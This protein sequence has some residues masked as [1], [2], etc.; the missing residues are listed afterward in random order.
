MNVNNVN[1]NFINYDCTS[2]VKKHKTIPL[3]GTYQ[4]SGVYPVYMRPPY[5]IK[6][7]FKVEEFILPTG[8]K[9]CT[10]KLITGQIISIVQKDG[11]PLIKTAF[12]VGSLDEPYGKEGISHF[13]EHSVFHG[14]K[15]YN[16]VE[17]A[18]KDI[19]GTSNASTNCN[20][21]DFYI[22]LGTDDKNA[23]RQALD[24]EADMVF[25]PKFS[26]LDK[27]RSIVI[28]EAEQAD[29]NEMRTILNQSIKNLLSIDR[30][31]VKDIIAGNKN[32]ISSITYNDM[33]NY[34]REY[35]IP[36]N[37][38][39]SI[40]TP[41][42]PDEIADMAANAFIQASKDI[43][44]HPVKRNK[45]TAINQIQ[46]K[47]IISK[48]SDKKLITFEFLF[49]VKTPEDKA[50]FYVLNKWF[51]EGVDFSLSIKDLYGADSVLT[52]QYSGSDEDEY[53][54]FENLK[55]QFAKL[56]A[57]QLDEIKLEK[58]KKQSS[59]DFEDFFQDADLITTKL[60]SDYF[61][62]HYSCEEIKR[63]INNLKPEDIKEYVKH[64]DMAKCSMCVIHP[65]GT[66][67]KDF[68]NNMAKYRNYITPVMVSKEVR[69]IN[70]LNNI[71]E[72]NISPYYSERVI[73]TTLPDN[74]NLTLLN[75]KTDKCMAIWYLSN[76]DLINVNPAIKYV[77]DS[78]TNTSTIDLFENR[79]KYN[80][81]VYSNYTEPYRMKIYAD[82]S[83]ENTDIAI[84]EMKKAFDVK[85]TEE[86]FE[87]AKKLAFE[88]IKK[89]ANEE[90][91]INRYNADKYGRNCSLNREELIN[92]LE[93]LT[94]NDVKTYFNALITG[95]SSSI[96][97]KAPFDKNKNMI[98]KIASEVNI[99]GFSFKQDAVLKSFYRDNKLSKCYLKEKNQPY[100]ANIYTY[101]INGNN[102]DTMKYRLL[103]EVLNLRLF[104]SLREK[105]GIAY[106]VNSYTDRSYDI[107]SIVLDI[108]T[109]LKDKED[110]K[111][112]FNE[113]DKEVKRL[114]ETP[115]D[116]KELSEA[117][118]NLKVQ[119][120]DSSSNDFLFVS[121]ISNNIKEERFGL[122]RMQG[123]TKILESITKEDI[124]QTARYVFK[125]KPDYLI[126]ADKKT[127][128]DN[129]E[130]FKEL[131]EQISR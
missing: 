48:E 88:T 53:N 54:A 95:A 1:S 110:I 60:N 100:Y 69:N 72:H 71:N 125:N 96:V 97:V 36:K 85:F 58:I 16:D 50:K 111:K 49:P 128:E 84:K 74:T 80:M 41:Y 106:S 118:N 24:I 52:F 81:L 93:K 19:G 37:A 130:Y 105:M 63:A 65:K 51:T 23:I 30:P 59:K 10:Y 78:M 34:H 40:V 102:N 11:C 66:T 62:G 116:E 17:Q 109:S 22:K 124:M 47:D 108:A 99:P 55:E 127:L 13:I 28:K 73:S 27:E 38:V 45:Y 12:K 90:D 42:N 86:E 82:F 122:N 61:N 77:L 76:P 67:N 83:A 68:E 7:Y 114:I 121:R 46:R 119:I 44:N 98:N 5:G 18:I 91:V 4:T 103:G 15:K 115:V 112:I 107:G 87:K 33:M 29:A 126:E 129:K 94:F 131:G 79:N 31:H 56:S 25:N 6:P 104:N 101:K 20:T 120:L 8:D 92:G 43:V 14:S 70:V 57:R 39:T 9:V 3:K 26:K 89:D 75:S 2:E 123:S 117:K 21:T 35:Y 32:S 113:F 64:F